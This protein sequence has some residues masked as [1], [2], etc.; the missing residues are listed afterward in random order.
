MQR[1]FSSIVLICFAVFGFSTCSPSPN[2]T[3][4]SPSLVP[5]STETVTTGSQVSISPPVTLAYTASPSCVSRIEQIPK[6]LAVLGKVVLSGAPYYSGAPLNAP[7]YLLDINSG[8][9]IAL[10]Q[11]KNRII[12]DWSFS[13]SP[14]RELLEYAEVDPNQ[15]EA[16]SETLHIVSGD[17]VEHKTI[18]LDIDHRGS[19][20]IDNNNLLIENLR[21]VWS[22]PQTR[23]TLF[24][25]NPFTGESSELLNEYPNQWNGDSLIWEFN[26]S[27]V[28]YS[29]DLTRVIYPTFVEPNRVVRMVDVATDDI[30][31]DVPTTDYGKFPLWAPDG[32][33]IAFVTQINRQASQSTIQDEIFILGKDGDLVQIT[34]LSQAN[35]YSYITG[36]SWSADSQFSAFFVNN[37]DWGKGR[38]GMHLSI[39]DTYTGEQREYCEISDSNGLVY[40]PWGSPIWSP[41]GEYI[42]VNMEDPTNEQHI[43]VIL[44]EVLT[45]KTF[46]VTENIRAVGWLK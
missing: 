20:W 5:I 6:T 21:K 11:N 46:F 22:A 43:L 36:M 25:V 38:N 8:E 15:S 32:R 34:H 17:G 28:I 10:P 18:T 24:L 13:M 33:R 29:P 1:K 45:G 4:I 26:L 37:K 31:I 19:I 44:I 12:V 30:L 3:L 7:S 40:V 35:N 16:T 27:R 23:A 14:N 41:D 2:A 42:L 39:V 9:K